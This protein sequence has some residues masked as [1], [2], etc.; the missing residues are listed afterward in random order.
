MLKQI[1][2]A[3]ILALSALGFTQNDFLDR[4]DSSFD[5]VLYIHGPGADDSY[6]LGGEYRNA[7]IFINSIENLTIKNLSIYD[8]DVRIAGSSQIGS[9]V[10][11]RGGQW[12]NYPSPLLRENMAKLHAWDGA[13]NGNTSWIGGSHV[14]NFRGGLEPFTIEVETRQ[15]KNEFDALPYMTARW[16]LSDSAGKEFYPQVMGF[17]VQGDSTF[18]TLAPRA[19]MAPGRGFWSCTNPAGY[20]SVDYR[21]FD[22]QGHYA[23]STYFANA[24]LRNSK[25]GPSVW[26]YNMGFENCGVVEVSGVTAWGNQIPRGGYAGLA[27]LFGGNIKVRDSQIDILSVSS[28][29]WKTEIDS[30]SPISFLDLD[31]GWFGKLIEKGKPV[32]IPSRVE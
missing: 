7:R 26:D 1:T 30:T 12:S 15:L 32:E 31:K 13:T 27:F 21:D 11:M 20:I 14:W 5:Q 4:P 19:D 17:Q 3:G 6:T 23:F 2:L 25:I 18:I 10:L 8:C 9:N 16:V 24:K 29:E 22:I 28:G